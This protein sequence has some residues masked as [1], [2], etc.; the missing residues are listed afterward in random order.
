M[1]LDFHGTFIYN[2][3]LEEIT[4]DA[5]ID[6]KKFVLMSELPTSIHALQQAKE[7][8]VC[9]NEFEL[10]EGYTSHDIPNDTLVTIKDT[11]Q[12]TPTVQQV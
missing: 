8:T 7:D 4:S 10:Q 2:F 3:V 1:D 11:P 12:R 6:D 9:L 5:N